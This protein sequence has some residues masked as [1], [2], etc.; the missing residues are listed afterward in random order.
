MLRTLCTLNACGIRSADRRGFTRWLKRTQPD[1]LCLQELRA[2]EADVDDALRSPPGYNTRWCCATKKGYSGVALYARDAADRYVVGPGFDHCADEGR[3]LR[4]DFGPLSVLSVYVPSGSSSPARQ[5]VKFE[6][7]EHLMRFTQRLID[8]DRA[9]FLCGDVNIAHTALDIARA[10]PN[11]KNSG[12]LP[13][14]RA[15]LSRL[16]EQ[17]WT[18]CFRAQHPGVPGL[19]SWWSNRGRAR[20]KDIGW[21]IDYVLGTLRAASMVKRAWIEKKA[22]LSDHAPVWIE[23]DS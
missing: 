4:A 15:W 10:K 13:E 6:Y 2:T 12:F 7:L 22:G 11:E 18:D 21:R 5:A 20:E 14:E 1:Y 17:G 8:E 3:V 23:F 16:L 19:Y 9:V